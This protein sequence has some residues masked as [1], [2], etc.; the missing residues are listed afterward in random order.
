MIRL[1]VVGDIHGAWTDADARYFEGSDYDR[2]LVVGDLAGFRWKDTLA[3]AQAL[4]R[5]DHPAIVVPG[6]HD[7]THAVQLVSEAVGVPRVGDW[8]TQTLTRRYAALRDAL[9]SHPLGAYS[10]HEVG[11]VTIVA[12]RPHSMGGP[13]LAFARHLAAG[14]SVDSL[15]ASAARLRALVDEVRTERVIFLAHNGPTGLGATRSDIWGCDF[16]RE[17]GDWGDPDLAEA[18]AYAVAQGRRVLAV[19]AGHM[20]RRIR[21]GGRRTAVVVR[22][23]IT[24][25]NAAEVGR[26]RDG[27]H[28]HVRLVVDGDDVTVEDR[29]EELS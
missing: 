16:K 22:D 24:Y 2:V 17:E 3:I 12:G 5:M 15:E 23:G 19:C 11:D 28:H 1:A 27:R 10:T 13:S 9:G 29:F 25:V 4:G 6:N 7:A 18:V 14:W 20:H 8:F 21:G 26:I